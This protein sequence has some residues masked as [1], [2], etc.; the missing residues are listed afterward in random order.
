[1]YF[2]DI[3][4]VCEFD[5]EFE[6][7]GKQDSS[8]LPFGFLEKYAYSSDRRAL[9][10]PSL[11]GENEKKSKEANDIEMDPN[12]KD[13]SGNVGEKVDLIE[14]SEEHTYYSLLQIEN[15]I[16]QCYKQLNAL[17]N[18]NDNQKITNK[19]NSLKKEFVK[20]MD[21]VVEGVLLLVSL[22]DSITPSSFFETF[23]PLLCL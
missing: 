9:L 18:E 12:N 14:G 4:F 11:N 6:F 15:E 20:L 17:E 10:D 22:C 16:E 23:K 21:H 8:R 2:T 3:W 5:S 13:A 1:M 19:L 7:L